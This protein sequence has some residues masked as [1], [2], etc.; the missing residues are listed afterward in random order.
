MGFV[1]AARL[2][3]TVLT[4]VQSTATKLVGAGRQFEQLQHSSAL[5]Q[6]RRKVKQRPT[7]EFLLPHG[8]KYIPGIVG[9]PVRLSQAL[10]IG[11]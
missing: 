4:Q 7:A 3:C 6:L 10:Q 11:I 1:P 9:E 2:H 8:Q 5:V